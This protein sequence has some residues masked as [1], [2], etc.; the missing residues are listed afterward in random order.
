VSRELD[1]RDFGPSRI[2]QSRVVELQTAARRISGQLAGAHRVEVTGFDAT[3]GNAS[4]V[5]SLD[6]PRIAGDVARR[7]LTHLQQIAP[8]LG[9][10]TAHPPEFVADPLVQRTSSGAQVTNL[11]QHHA[12]VP[13]FQ[14][15]MAVRFGPDGE[16]FDT[17][18]STVT[19]SGVP[20]A[21]P[22]LSV[23]RAVLA[24]AA[25]VATPD[26]DERDAVD[27]F[28]SP[29]PAPAVDLSGFTPIVLTTAGGPEQ[30]TTLDAGPCGNEI[31]AALV[32]FP[33]D[34]GIALAWKMELAMPYGARYDTIVD[35][36][37]GEV[38]FCR[39]TVNSAAAEGN[40]YL[41]DG[42]GVRV[43]TAFPRPLGDLLEHPSIG[44]RDWRWCRKC[45]G[46]F[47]GQ[48]GQGACPAGGAH[49]KT[50]SGDYR[51][52]FASAGAPGQRGWHWC[53]KC[54]GLFFV[55]GSPS[56]GICPAGGAHQKMGFGLGAAISYSLL[57][58]Q[59]L[60]RGQPNWRWCRKCAGL[61]YGG[62]STPGACPAG[63]AHDQTGSGNYV[64]SLNAAGLPSGF[65]PSWSSESSTVGSAT[66]AHLEVIAADGTESAGLPTAG[67]ETGGRLVFDP[68]DAT[69]DAQKV[70]NTFY[71]TN[72]MHDV[73]YV[74][75]F[76]EAAGNFQVSNLG[77]GSAAN[78]ALDARIYSGAVWGTASMWTPTDGSPPV[79]K[80]GLYEAS[81]RH[82]AFDADVVFHEF[83]HGV[84]SRLVGGP[85]NANALDSAQSSGMGEGWGDYVACTLNDKTLVGDWVLDNASGVRKYPYDA[86]YPEHFGH[87]GRGRYREA[88]NIGE[89]WCATLMEV[90]RST[91]KHLA[92]QLV[93]DALKLSPANPSFLDMR[94]AILLALQQ[95][96]VSGQLDVHQRDGV[97]QGIWAA[98]CRFG[99]G[100]QAASFGAQ[101]T[102]ISAD[103][104]LGDASWGHCGKCDELFAAG[105]PGAQPCPVGGAHAASSANRFDLV[106]DTPSAPC[107][108][109]WRRCG[110]CAVLFFAGGAAQ[111]VCAAGGTHDAADSP[112]FGLTLDAAGGPGERGWR[113]C[114]K[115]SGLF[116]A[117]LPV[118]GKP[119]P[120][121]CPAGGSHDKSASGSYS[122]MLAVD[123]PAHSPQWSSADLTA[124][125]GDVETS[126]DQPFAYLTDFPGQG[127]TARVIH[128]G[129][130]HHV[131]ELT[132]SAGSRWSSADLTALAG[133][134]E[135]SGR[136]LIACVTDFADQGPTAR[137][138]HVGT[139]GHVYELSVAPGG[140]WQS[141][142]LTQLAGGPAVGGSLCACVTNFGHGQTA[143]VI[144]AGSDW[145]IYELSVSAGGHWQLAD[146]TKITGAP[147]GVSCFAYVTDFGS[148]QTLR[149]VF[150]GQDWHV[151]ELNL[152]A[153]GEW[154]A[155]DLTKITKDADAEGLLFAYSTDIPGQGPTARVIY[156]DAQQRVRELAVSAGRAW[157]AADLT[158]A[159]GA[160]DAFAP[161]F[162]YVTDLRGQGPTARVV[163]RGGRDRSELGSHHVQE[164]TVAAGRPWTSADLTQAAGGPD[165]DGAPFGYVTNFAGQGPTARVL[166]RG[167]DKHIYELS[168]TP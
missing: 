76:D 165:A 112:T 159:S 101:Y 106:S 75:G 86:A 118:L 137:V 148:G 164:M 31:A 79:M 67:V 88:H 102:G 53:S 73:F 99:M 4:A 96:F 157:S 65:P 72:V 59:P 167:T 105:S 56:A 122:L 156:R 63:G 95:I 7:A 100:P 83:T 50:A 142:D 150:L 128:V 117:G 8:V 130:D 68:K 166:Y 58:R 17:V 140:A 131:H 153:G 61:F 44:H 33:R 85:L 110:K 25:H 78:D 24:A 133:G 38:V 152:S 62:S 114:K 47:Y 84:T 29:L 5:R 74:L 136:S 52:L 20:D 34:E 54:A 126:T 163:F 15:A 43:R 12:G 39:Q 119:I 125:S 87:V 123:A 113:W 138:F 6:A 94:D 66:D 93:V 26:A 22:A 70:L 162:G 139:Y 161:P 19:V 64:L 154:G 11:L 40:V 107:Q 90:N 77:A 30:K 135:G 134:D 121:N 149:V 9:L 120:A 36:G 60:R 14:A 69:G 108:H 2:T 51:L 111:G 21:A 46:L 1:V 57:D 103:F 3:T 127:P 16:L 80:M 82:T 132:V 145:H 32:W 49:D 104:T 144:Y 116:R 48:M 147:R 27:Q 160:A 42:G 18:G 91:D 155:A 151:H 55:G 158:T 71:F 35:A 124:I 89:I 109:G 92:L 98:F 10:D 28:G 45:E 168:I 13:V 41:R 23:E 143:R 81:G 141:A 37:T 146:L 129:T 115:C 97:W